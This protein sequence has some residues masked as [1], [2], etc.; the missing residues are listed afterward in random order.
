MDFYNHG[1][2]QGAL[3]K[4]SL[5]IAAPEKGR[6]LI[7]VDVRCWIRAATFTEES[8]EYIEKKEESG[9]KDEE[10]RLGGSPEQQKPTAG[11]DNRGESTRRYGGLEPEGYTRHLHGNREGEYQEG[12]KPL[13][14]LPIEGSAPLKD[15]RYR[16]DRNQRR[17]EG[18]Q[19]GD[20]GFVGQGDEPDLTD[21]ITKKEQRD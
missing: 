3:R 1:V 18:E 12:G 14:D 9:R 6:N 10:R 21:E 5:K 13:P 8:Y 2:A 4:S 15:V 20:S 7:R 17:R 11:I 19:Y 16:K